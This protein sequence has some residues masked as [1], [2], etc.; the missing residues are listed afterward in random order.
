[1]KFFSPLNKGFYDTEIHKS[2]MPADCVLVSEEDYK[3][4]FEAQSRGKIIQGNESGYPVAVDP[5]PPDTNQ[6]LSSIR[7]KR[8][9]LLSSTDKYLM[10][11]YPISPAKKTEWKLYRQQLR[12]LPSNID[13]NNIVWPTPPSNGNNKKVTN[14]G[15]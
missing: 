12:D 15:K 9:S 6:L 2:Q 14:G 10:V 1:M 8:D 3:A 13:P 11:D 4:I 5:P 7:T